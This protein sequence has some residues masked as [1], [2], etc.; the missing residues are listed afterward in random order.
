[1]QIYYVHLPEGHTAASDQIKDNC[2][3]DQDGNLHL[4]TRGE[5]IKKAKLFNGKIKPYGKNYTISDAKML[6]LDKST[7]IPQVV[8][9]MEELKVFGDH[10]LNETICY[11]NVFDTIIE[12]EKNIPDD[13]L[14]ELNALSV[15]ST[16]YHYI[17]L[18]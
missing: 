16:Y 18:L 8:F 13:V 9:L 4:Y 17:Q 14:V 6:Q 12:T 11:G 1:M 3:V 15:I 7:L 10:Q 5:A 2:L